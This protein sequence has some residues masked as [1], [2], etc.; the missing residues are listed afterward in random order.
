MIATRDLTA[1]EEVNLFY[2]QA[3]DQIGLTDGGK[4]NAAPPLARAGGSGAGSDG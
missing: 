4:G 2:D 3:A 1:F